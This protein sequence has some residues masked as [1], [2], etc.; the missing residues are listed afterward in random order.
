MVSA[1]NAACFDG[2]P[3]AI[4]EEFSNSQSVLIGKVLSEVSVPES[5][6]YYEG[7]NYAVEVQE[8]FKGNP[9]KIIP[10]FCENSSGRFPMVVGKTY[11]VFLYY[12]GRHQ[13]D[14]CGNSGLVS[15]KQEVLDAVL[16]LK[17]SKD[18]TDK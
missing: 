16:L 4:K 5:G 9:P 17:K 1:A 3:L 7:Q 15:E 10:V 13:I 2:H 11:V 6:K 12:D 8:V 18:G 14:N